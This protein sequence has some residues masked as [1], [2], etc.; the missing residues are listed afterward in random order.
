MRHRRTEALALA[1]TLVV[2]VLIG[3]GL[4][5]I[6]RATAQPAD[7]IAV[8]DLAADRTTTL[9]AIARALSLVG[10]GYVVFSLTLVA[11]VVLFA[12][13]HSERAAVVGLAVVGAVVMASTDKLLVGRPRPPVH[14]LEHV[15]SASFP[16]GHASQSTALFLGLALVLLARRSR[17]GAL[18]GDAVTVVLIL[19]IGFSRI[20]LGVH[21][22]TDVAGGMLLAGAWTSAVA[23]AFSPRRVRS[24]IG[25]EGG[26]RRCRG[27]APEW[28]HRRSKTAG[29]EDQPEL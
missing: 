22:P 2:L 21:Y 3:W 16:S 25:I 11:V 5:E 6:A 15:T 7:L 23:A 17:A 12:A 26:P 8:R 28:R 18:V 1:A 9:T 24:A 4:G 13:R 20:Y 10:S 19:A 14:H 29:A 27:P